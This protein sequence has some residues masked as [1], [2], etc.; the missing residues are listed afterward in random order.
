[1]TLTT[2][3]SS[4]ARPIYNEANLLESLSV[5]L[6]GAVQPTPFVTYIN[7][8]AKGQREIIEYGNGAHTHYSYDPLTFRLT[9]ILTRRTRDHIRL[10][11][12]IYVFD[13]T[14]NIAHIADHAQETVFF[15]NHVVDPRRGLCL[16]RRLPSDP[17]HRSR[18]DRAGR[19]TTDFLGRRAEDGATIADR[20]RRHAPVR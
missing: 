10:Q 19:A 14:G 8:N 16:R 3:D 15:N 5:N 1:M 6:R 11:D 20:R 12:L 2:P 17:C 4:V 9:H 13:P 18:A 7:Y